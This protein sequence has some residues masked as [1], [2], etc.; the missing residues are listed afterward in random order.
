MEKIIINNQEKEF[1]LVLEYENNMVHSARI[2]YLHPQPLS[3]FINCTSIVKG[4]CGRS[5]D[6]VPNSNMKTVML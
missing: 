6:F 3:D 5:T 4:G 1:E 2:K